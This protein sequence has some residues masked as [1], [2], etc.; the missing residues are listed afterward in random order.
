MGSADKV[1]FLIKDCVAYLTKTYKKHL[2]P[3]IV[4]KLDL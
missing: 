4:A 2:N 1:V 3:F